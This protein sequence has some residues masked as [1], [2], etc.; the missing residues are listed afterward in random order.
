MSV[1]L[2]YVRFIIPVHIG[3]R[4]FGSIDISPEGVDSKAVESLHLLSSGWIEIGMRGDTIAHYVSPGTVRYARSKEYDPP[5]S[6]PKPG[7]VSGSAEDFLSQ[8]DQAPPSPKVGKRKK[9]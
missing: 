5:P 1:S 2:D 4:D 7:W 6:E 3:V 9:S 8:A